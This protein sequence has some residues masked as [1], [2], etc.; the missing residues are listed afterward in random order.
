MIEAQELR[1]VVRGR[2]LAL[3]RWGD[4]SPAAP[5]A[6]LL[7]GWG[8]QAGVWEPLAQQ[9]A[10]LG[11]VCHAPDHR[12]HGRSAWAP[13]GSHYAF[14]EY[15]A[16][17]DGLWDRLGGAPALLIGHS[18]GGTIACLYASLRPER[19]RGLLLAD[20]LG[21]PRMSLD[22]AFD[23]YASFLDDQRRSLPAPRP[24]PDVGAL[25]ER[26]RRLRPGLSEA[27]AGRM[28]R[29]IAQPL[30]GGGFTFGWDPMHRTRSA[31]A[32]DADRFETH[33]R[34]IRG[35]VGLVWG[36]EGFLA[37]DASIRGR[38]GLLP[39]GTRVRELP[40]GHDLPIEATSELF[41]LALE[42]SE[43]A[44]PSSDHG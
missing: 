4:E 8:D 17:L 41:A 10:G 5:R 43:M 34:R 39:G 29:R 38:E 23:A 22:D 19:V 3:L 31:V 25:A 16:D 18:M 28:A 35:P 1:L 20:G 26:L 9:L 27:H 6:M 37:N 42:L 24:L 2:P 13:P 14:P 30:P 32:F 15:V 36:M 33:L 44:M 40:L 7:H 12:G 21:P 11:W